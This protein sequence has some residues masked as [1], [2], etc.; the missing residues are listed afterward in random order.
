[1]GLILQ[2]VSDQPGVN[3]A[4]YGAQMKHVSKFLQSGKEGTLRM[5][6]W[7]C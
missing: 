4:I 1:M 3:G 6:P 2:M 7:V 5:D